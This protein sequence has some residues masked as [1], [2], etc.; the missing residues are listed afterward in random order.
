[1]AK[2]P[3]ADLV[4][5]TAAIGSSEGGVLLHPADGKKRVPVPVQ[6]VHRTRSPNDGL[7]QALNRA[8]R[9][10]PRALA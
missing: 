1:M 2:L 3:H 9:R 10:T 5:F 6:P 4:R 7:P 8:T